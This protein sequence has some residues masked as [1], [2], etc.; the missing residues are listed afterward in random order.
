[1]CKA[2]ICLDEI[3]K[4]AERVGHE[5]IKI[6]GNTIL[7]ILQKIEKLDARIA[8]LEAE[9]AD[10]KKRGKDALKE[11]LAVYQSYKREYERAEYLEGELDRINPRGHG[12]APSSL[13]Q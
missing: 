5:C 9:N 7:V 12:N 1:M 2:C 11:Y 4:E 10:L 6:S 3:K 8:E 13:F